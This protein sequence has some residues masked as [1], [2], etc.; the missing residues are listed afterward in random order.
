[1]SWSCVLPTNR[2]ERFQTFAEA[3]GPLFRKHEVKVHVVQDLPRTDARISLEGAQIYSWAHL[4]DRRLFPTGT[5]MVRSFGFQMAWAD[6]SDYILSLDDDVLP[7]GDVFAA[8]ERAFTRGAPCS[9]YFDVGMLTT[10]NGQMRGFPYREREPKTVAIQY[11]GWSG[12]LDYDAPTQLAVVKEHEDFH[13]VVAPV[14]R[15]AAV[16]GCIMNAAWRREYTPLMWQLPMLGGL[17][18]RFGDIW[19]GLFAKKVLDHLGDVMVIN[20]EASVRHERASDPIVSLGRE[21]PGIPVNEHLWD[22]LHVEGET[23]SNSYRE[24]TNSAYEHFLSF[25]E[26]YSGHFRTCRNRWLS[27]FV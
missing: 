19:S 27:C 9:P 5:D 22:A 15:G 17:Y 7:E 18:N 10:Y 21:A 25:S 26:E 24:V 23:I 2:P 8:Y 14:P 20:G 6:G 1:M 13:P 3:W 12:V 16:T 4:G 11:G